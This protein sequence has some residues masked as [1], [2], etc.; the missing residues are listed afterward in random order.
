MARNPLLAPR[1]RNWLAF[2]LLLIVSG[3][4]AAASVAQSPLPPG[5]ARIWLYRAWEP[6]E[7]LNLANV[8]VN[9]SYFASVANGAATYRDVPPGRYHIAP[10]S[11]SR[12]FNQDRNVELA[13]GQQLYVKIVSLTSWGSGNSASRSFKR[14]AFYAWVIPPQIARAEI[15]RDRNGI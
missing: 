12:D 3:C 4:A 2:G 6:S 10:V 5:Q 7:S 1:W 15:A 11:F 8:N 14:D 9:G 13:P